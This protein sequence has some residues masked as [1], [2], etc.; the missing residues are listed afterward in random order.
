MDRRTLFRFGFSALT[1]ATASLFAKDH[2]DHDKKHGRGHDDDDDDGRGHGRDRRDRYF[3]QEDFAYLR[4]YYSGPRDLPRGLRKK[5]YRTGQ[6][7]PGWQKRLRPFPPVLIQRLPP[8]PPDCDRG[9]V[10]GYAVVYDRRTRVIVDVIDIVN[11]V[12][13]R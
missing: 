5:Y 13:G 3:R 6:L 4:Q 9:Y 2:D 7:P 11:A 1:A 10:D 12:S 8:P